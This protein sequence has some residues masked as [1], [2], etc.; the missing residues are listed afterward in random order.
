MQNVPIHLFSL[1]F[2]DHKS[3]IALLSPNI[4]KRYFFP[5]NSKDKLEIPSDQVYLFGYGLYHGDTSRIT[6]GYDV[7]GNVCG[8]EN[9]KIEGVPFSGEDMSTKQ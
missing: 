3:H 6:S 1:H 4:K 8:Q 9:A 2:Q 5:K 7:S